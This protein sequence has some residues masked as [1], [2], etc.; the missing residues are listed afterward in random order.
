MLDGIVMRTAEG[1][2][3]VDAPEVARITNL[4]IMLVID[5]ATWTSPSLAISLS[6]SMSRTISA[7]LVMNDTGW[8]VS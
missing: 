1:R 3:F 7:D 5:S 2:R 4:R 8:L 6:R